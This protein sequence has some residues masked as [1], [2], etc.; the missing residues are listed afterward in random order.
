M[1]SGTEIP[2]GPWDQEKFKDLLAKWIVAM[3]Q[4]FYTVDEPEFHDLMMYTHCP[5][6]NLKIPHHDTVRRQIMK[7]GNDTIKATEQ[8]FL[9]CK[10]PSYNWSYKLLQTNVKGKISISLDAW[11]S[12]NNYAFMAIVAHYVTKAGQL[13]M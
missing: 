11:T 10:L 6:P 8:I 9:V 12:S 3:D 13:G 7:M 1:Y 4:P 5:S 2:K